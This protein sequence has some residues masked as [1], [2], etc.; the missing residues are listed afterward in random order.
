MTESTCDQFKALVF[1]QSPASNALNVLYSPW[2]WC[3]WVLWDRSL[4]CPTLLFCTPSF[5]SAPCS[6]F[7]PWLLSAMTLFFTSPLLF[8][9]INS[10]GWTHVWWYVLCQLGLPENNYFLES[11]PLYCSQLEGFAQGL[12]CRSTAMTITLRRLPRGG[13]QWWTEVQC[14]MGF[15]LS[16]FSSALCPAHLPDSQSCWSRT[17]MNTH[18]DRYTKERYLCIL[19]QTLLSWSLL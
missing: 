8:G 5:C 2:P 9:I 14:P 18:S 12:S 4:S 15:C 3:C 1:R 7:F 17:Q 6:H 13:I 16:W 11:S 19:P 10:S